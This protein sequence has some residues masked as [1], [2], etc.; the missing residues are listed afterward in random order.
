MDLRLESSTGAGLDFAI[1]FEDSLTLNGTGAVS[2]TWDNGVVDGQYFAPAATAD[3]IVTGTDAN[4]CVNT[5]TM[6][7]T[8]N[9]LPVV[10]AG[11]DVT[12]CAFDTTT[13][14]ASGATS[15]V[16]STTA[17]TAAIDVSVSATTTYDV[18]GT[19]DNGCINTDTVVVNVND[20]PPVGSSIY[21]VGAGVTVTGQDTSICD[22][23]QIRLNGTG[24]TTYAWDNGVTD[25]VA[26]TP[27][28]T[29]TYVVE[30]TDDN[31]CKNNDTLTITVNP[32]PTVS[33]DGFTSG[34]STGAGL[35]FVICFEDSLTL[36]G[37]GAVSYT[38][39]N[40]VVDGQYFA[41]AAT[42]DY[43]VTGTDANSCV[44]TDTMTITV[45]SLPAVSAGSDVTICAFDTTTL[46]AS[47]ATSYVWST[48]ATTA[49]IDVSVSATTT[50][51]VTGTDD[52]GCI[53]TDTV[54]VNVND[55]PPV[56]SSI[57]LVGAGVTVTGQD[58]SI[59]DG[60]QIRLNG[61]GA[62]TYAWD[63]GVTDNVAFTPVSTTTYVVEGTDDNG[64]K[65]NDTLTITVNPL[66]TVSFDGFTSGVS[67]GAG[68]D[69]VICFEDSL[70]LN[71]TG[72][73]S[74]TWDNG[75]V[76]G[77]YFAPAATADYIVTGTDANSCVN[78]DTMTITV[79]SLPAVSAGSDVTICAFDTTTLTASGATSYV[80]S[81]TAT[82][83]AIDVSV[84][85]TTT[86]DVTGTDDNGCINTDTVVVNVNDLPPVG[87][88]IYLVG[89]GVTVTGQ[90]T[91]ICDG[92]QIRLNGT[93]A[94]TY[95][96]D[97]GVTD[98][99]A[100][101]P[102][103]TTTYV[104]E[105]TDDNGCKN[106]DTLTIT[107]NPLPTVGAGIDSTIC[108]E[109]SLTLN[110]TGAVSYTWDNGV[111]DGQ[112]FAP[113]ATA[114]Y[115]V[116]GTDANSCVN[117][118][119]MTITVNSLP[120]VSAGSDVTICAFDTTTLTASGATSYVWST[121]ATTAAID[122]SV[123][124][125]TTYDVTGTDDNG[126]IN[127]DTVVVNVNDL[128][129]VGSSIYLVG[130]G[131]TVTGQD[132]TVCDGDQIRLNG[133]SAT[134]YV[135]S[136]V[137]DPSNVVTDNV[138]FTPAT[139]TTYVVEGTDDN[140]CKNTDTLT[141]NI[142]PAEN[143]SFTY[144]SNVYCSTDADPSPVGIVTT[145]GKFT[146]STGLVIDSITGVIDL[147]ASLN[148]STDSIIGYYPFNNNANDESGN[149][150]NGIVNGATLVDDRFGNP[151]S[152]YLFDGTN[153][154]IELTDL[155]V[156]TDDNN[157][158]FTISAWI[159]TT[160]TTNFRGIVNFSQNCGS[161]V[162]V[163]GGFSIQSNGGNAGNCPPNTQINDGNWHQIV[164]TYIEGQGYIGFKD[165]VQ[166]FI[167]T[168]YDTEGDQ[169]RNAYIGTRNNND[170][171]DGSIDDIYIYDRSLSVSEVQALY[172]LSGFPHQVTYISSN[173]LCAD[174]S[175]FDLTINDCSDFDGDGIPDY[176][177]EDDDNDG[178][179]DIVEGVEDT[180]GD[181]IL[182]KFD[183]D[184][185]NDGIADIVEAGGTDSDGDGL[186]D[187]FTDTDG[188]GLHDPYDS[189]NGGTQINTR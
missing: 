172:N 18:T 99:V 168:K 182:D 33:F 77:Q 62:T 179:P 185:D 117:T 66:P 87:S 46:T 58:T 63:N 92:D 71:G 111:V 34:A 78:T 164:V 140:G 130:A 154:Y 128:P 12:I 38:W 187:N 51:D 26:F 135:W 105:G 155:N 109:D 124:A 96:W 186:V 147:S 84:S 54:V 14:T 79:N 157:D 32:L 89:A 83:A 189:D 73:V 141:I 49:A 13:L 30:G 69:F 104:V 153:D 171:F 2:Y 138:A 161:Y 72:A 8:V 160:N 70:T 43:I 65:N 36:N 47:G 1:C 114:D 59:C 28:S 159:K 102:V 35:D 184:S 107:V 167:V 29:T 178:I 81:T 24:A 95:A 98:N 176:L 3:Y 67:T 134:S 90:D 41:P 91:S 122:V 142:L 68:L 40:G 23:D 42:A 5:D 106:N 93:G 82:T 19:D 64:C 162:C 132:T 156:T 11:S 143:A 170:F 174:T 181:G 123:S 9:S 108:F 144:N 45:N 75:V 112:Y 152:A 169:T 48:T 57:Y 10:S 115:I 180:D 101:T 137:N 39:D 177:D 94:T 20:L 151:N 76:D 16:W 53:N 133:T 74:Y 31:G 163:D 166:V 61:T 4:S 131:V 188:D 55:L 139:T 158:E 121:T 7:I 148:A 127:T 56:G 17:T 136:D 88:S 126:C 183:L 15:Y 25:N 146:S 27:A 113:A 145:G 119:T 110:G 129:P 60:D 103:S 125:T 120:A 86:Y 100:F 50:Y 6:T 118:D 173:S 80:W 165:G 21:L 22:G 44:N 149:N 37:T 150:N 97:N 175:T 85:A 116:T 52:N